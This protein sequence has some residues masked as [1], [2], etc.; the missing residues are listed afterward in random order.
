MIFPK[1]QTIRLLDVT[2]IGPVI[3]WSGL[4][5]R[6][7]NPVLGSIVVIMGALTIWYN[8]ENY[9]RIEETSTLSE[10]RPL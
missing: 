9:L 2:V 7:S 8:A 10:S 4:K 3:I 6:T 1:S 5:N